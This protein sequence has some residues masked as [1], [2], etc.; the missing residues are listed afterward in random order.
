MRTI[1]YLGRAD[2]LFGGQA[3]T[4]SW[5]TILKVVRVLEGQSSSTGS[6]SR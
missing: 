3:T 4:R 6:P 5:N 1:G 2:K